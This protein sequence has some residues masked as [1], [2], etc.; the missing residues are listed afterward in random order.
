M[1]TPTRAYAPLPALGMLMACVLLG[2]LVVAPTAGAASALRVVRDVRVP[3]ADGASITVD[4]WKTRP[5]RTGRAARVHLR[6][7]ALLVHGG[8]W[9]SGDKRQWEQ[10]R[11]A[12]R[13]AQRGWLVVNANYR[14]ACTAGVSAREARERDS[15]LCGH[16]MRTSIADVRATLRYTSRVARNWGGNPRRIVLFGA[17]AGGQ[18]AMLAGSDRTRPKGVRAVIAIAP[19]TDLSWVGARPELPL[20]ASAAKS[21]G[22]SMADCPGAWVAA[23]PIASVRSGTTPPTWIFN[24]GGDPITPMEPVRSYVDELHRSGI[25][26]SLLTTADP[27]AAC[28]GAIPCS[29][30]PLAGTDKDM[31][32]HALAWLGPRVR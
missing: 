26:A 22:C 3:T 14:L 21:I 19:P 6:P 32:E 9:H 30:L 17:S 1:R 23:S 2:L 4:L 31:F 12:Q 8:G 7:V 28:H 18:L 15:R 20:F 27:N 5:R 10:S 29:G 16:A 25:A 24:A 11:W 13:L